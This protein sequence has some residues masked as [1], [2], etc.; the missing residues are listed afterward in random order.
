M[1]AY[2]QDPRERIVTALEAHTMSRAQVAQTFDV[3]RSFVQKLWRRWQ[4]TRSVELL[5]GGARVYL[6]PTLRDPIP[7]W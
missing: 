7:Q 1:R 6:P 5:V 3:S 2:S 4:G